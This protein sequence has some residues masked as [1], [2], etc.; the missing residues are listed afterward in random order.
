MTFRPCSDVAP[1]L[2][3]CF[4][5]VL[6]DGGGVVCVP[7]SVTGAPVLSSAAIETY[8]SC[9]TKGSLISPACQN[10]RSAYEAGTGCL[11]K[12]QADYAKVLQ[13]ESS[14]CKSKGFWDCRGTPAPCSGELPPAVAPTPARAIAPGPPSPGPPAPGPPTPGPTAPVPAAG[15]PCCAHGV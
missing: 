4:S 10:A 9:V 7:N 13:R 6:S 1:C 8:N 2:S 11:D 3:G 5:K 15:L 12:C 14:F